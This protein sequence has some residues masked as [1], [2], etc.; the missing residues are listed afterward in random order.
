MGALRDSGHKSSTLS[1]SHLLTLI[2]ARC[3]N[4]FIHT[5]YCARSL[6]RSEH[7]LSWSCNLN[8]QPEVF[9]VPHSSWPTSQIGQ[10][11]LCNEDT[12]FAVVCVSW[13][14]SMTPQAASTCCRWLTSVAATREIS[15]RR[16]SG[17]SSS[18]V[19]ST[20]LLPVASS[21]TARIRTRQRTTCPHCKVEV[22]DFSTFLGHLENF[23]CLH[24]HSD[25]SEAR[26][27]VL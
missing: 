1:R 4:T 23:C 7:Y 26:N 17:I 20:S 2:S 6:S 5:L 22:W 27:G 16:Y 13:L 10:L 3:I 14:L 24:L 18:F 9:K 21:T 19:D 25:P 8:L 15:P 12:P 11:Q